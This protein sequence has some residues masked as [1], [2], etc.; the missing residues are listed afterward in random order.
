MRAEDLLRSF[1][2]AASELGP[3]ESWPPGLNAAVRTVLS[4][5]GPMALALGPSFLLVYNDAYARMLG[6]KHPSGFGCP[7]PEVMA[8]SWTVPGHGDVVERVF[9][10]GEPFVEAETRLPVRRSGPGGPLQ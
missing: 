1:D 4:G 8:E 5:A 10:T 6:A 9:R 2:W 7:L 3:R